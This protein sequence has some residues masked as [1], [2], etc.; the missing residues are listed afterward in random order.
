[1][2]KA[3]TDPY[4][5]V[6]IIAFE[7]FPWDIERSLEVALIHSFAIPSISSLLIKTGRLVHRT[8]ERVARTDKL[9]MDLLWYGLSSTEGKATAEKIRNA[10][11]QYPISNDEYLFVL[12]T[13]ILEPI[14][15]MEVYGPRPFTRDEK[16]AWFLF[17]SHF[18]KSMG[19]AHLPRD[20]GELR[21]WVRNFTNAHM[22]YAPDNKCLIDAVFGMLQKQ[23]KIPKFFLMNALASLF[24]PATCR[25]LGLEP[26]FPLF[27]PLLRVMLFMGRKRFSSTVRRDSAGAGRP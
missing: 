6:R 22:Y 18:G 25:A 13:F 9:I 2:E 10:H 7:T 24:D 27:R 26:P 1:M 8:E 4:E 20:L 16:D 19:I 3:R 23:I 21:S 12:S 14:E 5:A 11:A 17:W 15:W